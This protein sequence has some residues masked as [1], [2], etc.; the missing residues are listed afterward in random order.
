VPGGQ[1][2]SWLT[3]SMGDSN[4]S[5]AGG[6]ASPPR[7]LPQITPGRWESHEADT[8]GINNSKIP[9]VA[10]AS[11]ARAKATSAYLPLGI[12][13]PNRGRDRTMASHTWPCP[14]AGVRGRGAPRCSALLSATHP[15][16]RSVRGRGDWT[17]RRTPRP[18][19]ASSFS[20]RSRTLPSTITGRRHRIPVSDSRRRSVPRSALS[21]RC[22]RCARSERA[23]DDRPVRLLRP[24]CPAVGHR[25]RRSRSRTQTPR[26][27]PRRRPR[28]R[29]PAR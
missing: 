9:S 27:A 22:G 20:R 6:S 14:T 13:L 28:H 15:G 2:G 16:G 24:A 5:R 25:S 29:G 12:S 23:P 11:S 7:T 3:C 18:S 10:L 1:P 21:D 4:R 19:A 26:T 17:L 8:V